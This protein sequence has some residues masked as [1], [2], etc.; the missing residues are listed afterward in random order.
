MWVRMSG[1]FL[2]RRKRTRVSRSKKRVENQIE[3]NV[4]SRA[5][6]EARVSAAA[7]RHSRHGHGF[8]YY[9]SIY[10]RGTRPLARVNLH[11]QR[12]TT[13]ASARSRHRV[14][15]CRIVLSCRNLRAPPNA[16]SGLRHRRNGRLSSLPSS[17][18][19][20]PVPATSSGPG[21]FVLIYTGGGPYFPPSKER[22]NS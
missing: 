2:L 20:C 7:R 4:C 22:R 17:R 8:K 9:I 13:S 19:G 18:T 12:T 10:S 21:R 6:R 15:R 1:H 11:D 3:Q 16:E 5:A 14:V